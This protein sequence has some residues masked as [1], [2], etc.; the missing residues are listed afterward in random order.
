[1]KKYI[2]TVASL[3]DT[4]KSRL[5]RLTPETNLTNSV[6]GVA[7]YHGLTQPLAGTLAG[8]GPNSGLL[9]SEML[10]KNVIVPL[11]IKAIGQTVEIPE[12]IVSVTKKKRIV[13]TAVVGGSGTVKEFIAEDDMEIDITLGIV[14]T[15]ANGVICDEYPMV[16]MLDLI[17]VLD[18]R[19]IDVWSPFLEM[20]NLD[21]GLY[22]LVVTDYKIQQMTHTNRQA[23]TISAVSDF[24]YQIF[25]EEN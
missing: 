17:D 6:K 14:A 3:G 23:I 9:L 16:E 19:Q 1:M 22:R 5:Y 7:G 18:A 24:D 4:V 20:F 21:G 15:D 12:A 10:G 11:V 25:Y 13:S 8:N 2:F